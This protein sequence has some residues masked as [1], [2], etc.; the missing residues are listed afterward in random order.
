MAFTVKI[1]CFVNHPLAGHTAL[2]CIA[3]LAA[4]WRWSKL[5]NISVKSISVLQTQHT[6]SSSA[7]PL[8]GGKLLKKGAGERFLKRGKVEREETARPVRESAERER[9]SRDQRRETATTSKNGKNS[10][11]GNL[12][13][14][15]TNTKNQ[16]NALHHRGSVST[17]IYHYA[18]LSTS[19]LTG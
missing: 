10:P 6:R 14:R 4:E 1:N 3:S 18:F 16:G 5:V 11:G 2:L 9:A 8:R 15:K 12:F 19:G 13:S 17:A 7:A